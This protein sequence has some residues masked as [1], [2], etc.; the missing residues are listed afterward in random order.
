[1]KTKNDLILSVSKTNPLIS[2]V[3]SKIQIEI[4]ERDGFKYVNIWSDQP[5]YQEQIQS[6][7]W[8]SVVASKSREIFGIGTEVHFGLN[9][10]AQA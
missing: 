3:L 1:M 7:K 9:E 2:E 5:Y 4:Q 8:A 10:S 6:Q